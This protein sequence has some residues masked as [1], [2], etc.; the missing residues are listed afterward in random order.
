MV[1][2]VGPY[3]AVRRLSQVLSGLQEGDIKFVRIAEELGGFRQIGKV[4]PLLQQFET[5]ERARQ[6]AIRGGQQ[7]K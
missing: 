4:I 2:F 3:E 1:K 7:F 5:A 6:A